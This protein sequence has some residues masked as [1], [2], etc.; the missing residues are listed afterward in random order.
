MGEQGKAT[1]GTNSVLGID[2]GFV[3]QGTE[4]TI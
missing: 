3:I 2:K 1:P 4:Q